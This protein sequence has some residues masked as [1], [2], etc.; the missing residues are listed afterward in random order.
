M[1]LNLHHIEDKR[2]TAAG[3]FNKATLRCCCCIVLPRLPN[4]KRTPPC[5]RGGRTWIVQL[6]QTVW[7]L[8]A[9]SASRP[10]PSILPSPRLFELYLAQHT[11][12]S[13]CLRDTWVFGRILR[14]IFTWWVGTPSL[15]VRTAQTAWDDYEYGIASVCERRK[16]VY[17]DGTKL[18]M[19]LMWRF[20]NGKL[21]CGQRAT[22]IINEQTEKCKKN[23]YFFALMFFN[24]FAQNIA[25]FE[26]SI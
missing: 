2:Q 14:M 26:D 11:I 17:S 4:Q 7:F 20:Y 18:S 15:R 24:I 19:M 25:T 8:S 16:S 3:L 22:K 9:G 10:S 23:R 1:F 12:N 5:Q 21:H 13:E 6:Q